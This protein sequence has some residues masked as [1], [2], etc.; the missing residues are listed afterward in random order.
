MMKMQY[1]FTIIIVCQGFKNQNDNDFVCLISVL[2]VKNASLNY[3]RVP[4]Q[5]GG[6][7]P[8][9]NFMGVKYLVACPNSVT[10]QIYICI[11]LF[12]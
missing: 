1:V 5:C 8:K 10:D 6:G 11:L 7:Y 9:I 4:A 3:S 2:I 12:T